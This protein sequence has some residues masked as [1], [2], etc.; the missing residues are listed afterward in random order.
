MYKRA[1]LKVPQPKEKVNF[2][3]VGLK[4]SNGTQRYF[5][6]FNDADVGL[7]FSKMGEKVII[8]SHM[9]DD[10]DTD[11]DVL[12]NGRQ[13]CFRDLLPVKQILKERRK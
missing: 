13:C 6:V 9:D 8:E 5:K 3:V 2:Q 10:V 7:D 4:Q 11:T 1:S 12:G